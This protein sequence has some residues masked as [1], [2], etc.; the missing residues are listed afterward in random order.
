MLDPLHTCT[1]NASK[2]YRGHGIF[3]YIDCEYY[4]QNL[5]SYNTRRELVGSFKL[6][7]R[8]HTQEQ[9]AKAKGCKRRAPKAAATAAKKARKDEEEKEHAEE[10]EQE[11][12]PMMSEQDLEERAKAEAD[13]Q[14][15]ATDMKAHQELQQETGAAPCVKQA[16]PAGPAD[17]KA[18][19]DEA[20][21]RVNL[22]R[23]AAS[24]ERILSFKDM[25]DC[26][27]R[28]YY[29]PGFDW[30]KFKQ[31]CLGFPNARVL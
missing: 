5:L 23:A 3:L 13:E 30:A 11:E 12:G 24:I 4:M 2:P 27:P 28:A 15:E 25:A 16:E 9:A 18:K 29:K 21:R 10:S 22:Q 31:V 19:K 26:R 6:Q 1:Y 7:S 20:K 17:K 14:N 8:V